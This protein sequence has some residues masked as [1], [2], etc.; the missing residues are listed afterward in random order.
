[1]TSKSEAVKNISA[2]CL[3]PTQDNT[4]HGFGWSQFYPTFTPPNG[5]E[6]IYDAFQHKTAQTLQGSQIEGI[7][8]TYDGSGYL[9]EMR[10]KLSFIQGNL[11]LLKQMNWVDRQTRAVLVEFSAYNPNINLVMVS[12]ILVEFLAS[13]SILTKANFEPLNLFGESGSLISFKTISELIFLAF[14]VYYFVIEI[15]EM[16]NAD[17]K[18]YLSEFWSY[19]EWSI[20]ITACIS[21]MMILKRLRAAQEVLDFF[22][23][24]AGYGYMKLQTVNDCNQI[25]TYSLGICAALGTIKFLKMLRFNRHIAYLGMTLKICLHELVFCSM[26]FFLI[27]LAFVQLMYFIYNNDLQGY[28]SPIKSMQSAFIT[29]LGKFDAKQFLYGKS[30][31][32]GPF[33]FASYNIVM[34][35]F[36]MNIFVSI[37]TDSFD[38][39]R[40][41]A[42]DHPEKY[43]VDIHKYL[44]QKWRELCFKATS[45]RKPPIVTHE[46]YIDY[47]AGFNIQT[48]R[49]IDV[50]AAVIYIIMTKIQTKF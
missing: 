38:K 20:I 11:S 31:I 6:S 15:R 46:N 34:L 43:D 23:Q 1:M 8:G 26:A 17:I 45:K 4:N 28:A 47:L 13:G 22:K 42:K 25:L 48:N 12:T 19:I 9:Y 44:S 5:Y 18:E 40:H 2:I 36:V 10:G 39:I 14:I 3:Y 27:W 49:L 21:C 35:T 29:I 33:V 37:I 50:L 24:T 32:L 7:Y 41:D 30:T 16:I